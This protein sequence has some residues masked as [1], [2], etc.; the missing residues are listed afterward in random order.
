MCF[1]VDPPHSFFFY[2]MYDSRAPPSFSLF[3]WLQS[4]KLRVCFPGCWAVGELRLPKGPIVLCS[5]TLWMSIT[6]AI[7]EEEKK[8]KRGG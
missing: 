2:P 1:N 4:I 6:S 8:V 5:I 7:K 3:S